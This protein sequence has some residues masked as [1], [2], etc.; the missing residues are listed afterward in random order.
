MSLVMI[1]LGAWWFGGSSVVSAAANLLM[2]PLTGLVVVPAAG[3][4]HAMSGVGEAFLD[5]IPM[6][7]ISGGTRTD[8][9]RKYQLHQM[10]QQALMAPLTKAQFRC[11]SQAEIIPTQ[12]EKKVVNTRAGSVMARLGITEALRISPTVRPG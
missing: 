8:S 4:T 6:L 7:I 11:L 2:V 3:L 5:G 10:D 12:T 9:G 1:P